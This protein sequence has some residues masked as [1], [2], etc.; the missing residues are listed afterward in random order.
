MTFPIRS[1]RE[2]VGGLF[3]L[4]RIL[5]KIRLQARDGRLPE[6]Y[7]LGVIEGRRTFDDRVCRLLGVSYEELTARTLAGG[8]DE[9]ILEWCLENGR[10]LDAEQIEVWN[11]FMSKRG[12]RDDGAAS[13]AAQK[14]QA[15]LSGRDDIQTFFDLMD[16]EEGRG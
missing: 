7:H 9:D 14:E 6:G 1:P 5:D 3:V 10:R 2:K 12:W 4:G 11:G 16:A 15:G 8:S 13:L